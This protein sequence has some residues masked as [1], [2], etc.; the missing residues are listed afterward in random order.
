MK[1]KRLKIREGKV[2]PSTQPQLVVNSTNNW[3][4]K[5]RAT[6]RIYNSLQGLQLTR[7]LNEGDFTLEGC[8][9]ELL[10]ARALDLFSFSSA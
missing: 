4:V 6:N 5:P 8:T 10:F 2:F 7:E 9:R 3:I 1:N